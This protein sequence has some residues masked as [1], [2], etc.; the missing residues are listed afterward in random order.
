M[1][2]L[3]L[4]SHPMWIHGLPNG[5]RDAGHKVKVSVLFR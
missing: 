5:F 1:R 4:E 2:V 3:F